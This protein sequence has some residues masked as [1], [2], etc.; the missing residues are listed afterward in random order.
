MA[1]I[2]RKAKSNINFLT[3]D[4]ISN[5]YNLAIKRK[6]MHNEISYLHWHEFF[7][8]EIIL[9]G[10]CRQSLNGINYEFSAGM[11]TLLSPTDYHELVFKDNVELITIM[12]DES[13]LPDYYKNILY[14]LSEARIFNPVKQMY[15][16][17]VYIANAMLDESMIEKEDKQQYLSNLL[18][19]IISDIHYLRISDS[20]LSAVNDSLPADTTSIQKALYYTHVHFRDNPSL[21]EVAEIAHYTKNYFCAAFK[22]TLGKT[23]V[24]YLNELKLNYAKKVLVTTELRV[25][26]ICYQS[27]F[28]SLSNFLKCFRAEFGISPQKYRQQFIKSLGDIDTHDKTL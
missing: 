16:K 24:S 3:R 12:F 4:Y 11:L 25:S 7:E 8:I 22:N 26:E 9:S 18:C 23:Y 17:I 13:I 2:I 27:G 5:N 6:T 14:Q 10:E 28:E 21:D 19:C 20:K 1:G 15:N